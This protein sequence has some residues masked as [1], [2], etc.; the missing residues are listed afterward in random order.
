MAVIKQNKKINMSKKEGEVS[1][2]PKILSLINDLNKKYGINA[3]NLGVPKDS[4]GNISEI[5]RISTGVVSLD[6]ALGGGIPR[7]RFIQ[8]S[9]AYSSTKT[10]LGIHILREAQKLGLNCA[11]QDAE[12]TTDNEYMTSLG[13]NTETLLYSRPDGLE[14]CTQ[15]ILDYQKSGVVDVALFDSIEASPPT[16]EYESSM[17][18]TIRMGIKQQLLGEFFRK[19]Q[20][21]NN[22]L[23]REGKK[24][25]TLVAINQLREKIG[26]YGD[27]EYTPGGRSIGF[28]ASVDLRLRRGDWVTEGK[29]DNKEMVGQVV[30]FKIEKNKTYKRMQ[31]G[32]FDFYFSENIA[33]IQSGYYDN[34]K[35]IIME[36]IAWGLIE[37]GGAWFYLD[38]EKNLKFQGI[39]GLLEYLRNNENLVYV[40]RDKILDLARRG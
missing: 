31:T 28:A 37:R 19:Y 7:G 13:V 17:Q 35:A 33:G 40:L 25:F 12:G 9:G 23:V 39:D 15:M 1:L 24:P 10:T 21:G 16:K 38:R 2:D 20:A 29:G 30:K 18:D 3:V 22:R 34:F 6:I 4:E 14:E 32:E 36:S 8:I 11:F 5:Q 26:A 27:S